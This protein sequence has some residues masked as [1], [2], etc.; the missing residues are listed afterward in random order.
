MIPSD[1]F[2]F[3]ALEILKTFE[4][5]SFFLRKWL[6]SY[7]LQ[8]LFLLR[9]PRIATCFAL[10]QSYTIFAYREASLHFYAHIVACHKVTKPP[11]CLHVWFVTFD[12]LKTFEFR[13]FFLRKMASF[14]CFAGPFLTSDSTD[15]YV[16]C[17]LAILHNIRIS[18][19]FASLL[20]SYC[21]VS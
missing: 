12:I 21:G 11:T 17:T 19:S 13:S 2:A 6:H 3:H 18:R 20:C 4:F 9:I 7:V 1:F 16:L 14:S 8:V 5:R 15:C 10:S